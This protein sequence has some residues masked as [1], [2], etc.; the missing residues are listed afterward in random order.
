MGA[1][2]RSL[3]QTH[4]QASREAYATVKSKIQTKARSFGNPD[5]YKRFSKA[6]EKIKEEHGDIAETEEVNGYV[7]WLNWEG[8]FITIGKYVGYKDE[9]DR[10]IL[11][12]TKGKEI[13]VKDILWIEDQRYTG[14]VLKF[15]LS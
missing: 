12:N 9:T 3:I 4:A 10:I 15:Q 14:A 8:K 13:E 5:M 7:A 1:R 2:Q 11:E 6:I